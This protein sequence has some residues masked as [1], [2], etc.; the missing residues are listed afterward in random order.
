MGQSYSENVALVLARD[1]KFIG[2]VRWNLTWKEEKGM[3][4]ELMGSEKGDKKSKLQAAA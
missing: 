2:L 4:L 1:L 3:L